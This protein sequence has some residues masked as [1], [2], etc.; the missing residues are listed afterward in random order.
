MLMASGNDS[1]LIMPLI[2]VGLFAYLGYHVYIFF[3]RP[4]EWA[5]M[6]RRKHER[7]M[8]AAEERKAKTGRIAGV[9]GGVAKVALGNFFKHRQ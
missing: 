4:E 6:Q 8:A 3:A 5:A 9:L 2:I 1:G 7:E